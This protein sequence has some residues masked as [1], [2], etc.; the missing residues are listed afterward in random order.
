MLKDIKKELINQPDKLMQVL[1][2]YGYC[3]IVNHGKYISFGRDEYSSK[4]SIA[5]TLTN[6]DF[7]FVNDYARNINKDIFSFISLQRKV[8]FVEVLK[9]VKN[10]LG[11]TDYYDYFSN[12]GAFG[13][14]YEKIRKKSSH[15]AIRIYD[16]S[17]LNNYRRC[18]NL[19]FLKDNI[20]LS[21]QR[22]FNIRYDIESQG[23]VIPIY[24]Q[25]GQ[26]M[27]IKCRK[28]YDDEEMKY[29]YLVPC[30]ASETLY[31]YSQNY[32]YLMD[33]TIYIFESEKSVMQCNTY[34]IYNC[35]ALGSG[36]ISNKQIQ[37]ILEC[38]PKQV[39]FLHDNQY[40][41]EAIMNNINKLKRYSRFSDFEIGY[42]DWENSIFFNEGKISPSDIGKDNFEYIVENEIKF[43]KEDIDEEKI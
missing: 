25:F 4:K 27:G 8:E 10:T 40:D 17:I 30:R 9:V 36:T 1:D 14:F 18:G 7:L 3:H 26:L 34:G 38:H 42:W 16:N 5:I 21:T 29:F 31:G 43:V 23:I 20:S 22:K 24:D 12:K 41:I 6:N 37:M 39:I 35:V 32:N 28:N 2:Y 15:T 11:I 19:R 33:N 13:G